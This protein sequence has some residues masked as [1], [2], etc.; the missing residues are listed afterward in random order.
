MYYNIPVLLIP[1]QAP[2]VEVNATPLKGHF[3]LLGNINEMFP[4]FK[5]IRFF[6]KNNRL[7]FNAI[8]QR[9]SIWEYLIGRAIHEFPEDKENSL[10]PSQIEAKVQI[11][12]FHYLL[13]VY[14]QAAE[15]VCGDNRD[16]HHCEE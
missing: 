6:S 13:F 4:A 12:G 15:A 10:D 5:R 1:A 2:S 11:Y 3:V 8:D 14:H 9:N 7:Q 16:Q